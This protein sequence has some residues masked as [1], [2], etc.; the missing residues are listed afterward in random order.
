MAFDKPKISV[1]VITYNQEKL[2][3]R[4][5][6][7]LICQKDYLF[8]II[9]S[10]DCSKDNTWNVI[11]EYQQS[12]P[13]LIKPFRNKENMGV[14]AHLQS[15]WNRV[16]GDIVFTLAGDDIFCDKIFENTLKLIEN[17]S[18][19]Y[20][21]ED[22]IVLFDYK[23]RFKNGDEKITSNS[24]IL[25]H[26]GLSL[27]LRGLIFNRSM[28][29][30]LSIVKKRFF[31]DGDKQSVSYTQEA[32]IDLQPHMFA[33]KYLYKPY[34]GSV[35]YSQIGT[36]TQ[37]NKDNRL[38]TQLEY[39]NKALLSIEKLSNSDKNWLSYEKNKISFLMVPSINRFIKYFMGLIKITEFKYGMKF[40]KREYK[41]FIQNII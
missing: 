14:Y 41:M 38:Q 27:K 23:T 19:D 34:V 1:I 9:V 11:K 29:L 22:F 28:G 4:A 24:R 12:H 10:D 31:V 6:D 37:L 39:C 13:S 33:Q 25:K 3:C 16:K 17:N 26:N 40:L 5:L 35:Y 32:I 2:I 8:E 20:K 18:L 15:N 7:S 21:K 36:S 30:S